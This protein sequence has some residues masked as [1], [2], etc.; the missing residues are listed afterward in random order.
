MIRGQ[1]ITD[2]KETAQPIGDHSDSDSVSLLD[3]VKV[4]GCP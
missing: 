1:E 4:D 3:V 2:L